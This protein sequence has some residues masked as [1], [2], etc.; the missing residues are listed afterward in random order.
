MAALFQ[1][2]FGLALLMASKSARSASCS[3]ARRLLLL[4]ALEVLEAVHHPATVMGWA[5]PVLRDVSPPSCQRLSPRCQAKG[6]A[7]PPAECLAPGRLRRAAPAALTPRASG[8]RS[9]ELALKEILP[10]SSAT[11]A[12]WQRPG[13]KGA[14]LQIPRR[15]SFRQ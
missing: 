5:L 7:K 6:E 15:W 8:P 14:P 12:A 13:L 9:G 3:I 10:A 2:D 1:Q 11:L 4:F